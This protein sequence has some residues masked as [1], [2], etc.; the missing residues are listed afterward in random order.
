[1]NCHYDRKEKCNLDHDRRRQIKANN[2]PACGN[3]ALWNLNFELC[4]LGKIM[5]YFFHMAYWQTYAIGDGIFFEPHCNQEQPLNKCFFRNDF[6]ECPLCPT[7]HGVSAN[8]NSSDMTVENHTGSLVP[9][10]EAPAAQNLT[11]R[12]LQT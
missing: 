9:I 12:E 7:G 10:Q 8:G 4:G 3:A 1:M 6:L 2:S 11:Q 5:A